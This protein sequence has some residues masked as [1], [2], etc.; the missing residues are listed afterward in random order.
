[1]CALHVHVEVVDDDEGVAVID[2]VR[3][4]IPVLVAISANSPYWHG[5]DTGYDSWRSRVWNMWPTSGPAEPFRELRLSR[6]GASHGLARRG[7][8]QWRW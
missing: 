3:P 7:T 5:H 1:M 8:R 4:W 6:G 2:R